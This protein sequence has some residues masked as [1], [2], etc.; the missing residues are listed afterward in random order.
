VFAWSA[1]GGS[2]STSGVFT[3]PTTGVTCTVTATSGAATGT[4]TVAL[5]ANAAPTVAQAVT[6]ISGATV[7]GK[8]ASLSVLGADDGGESNLIYRWSVTTAPAGAAATFNVNGTNAAKFTTVT[9]TKAGVYGLTATI[10]DSGGLCVS[11]V[12]TVVA[13]P[14]LASFSVT[15]GGQV[16][17]AASLLSVSG[18]SQAM[19][20]SGLDQFGNAIS[21]APTLTWSTTSFPVGAAAPKFISSGSTTTVTFGMAGSYALTASAPGTTLAPLTTS[22]SVN[23]TLTRIVLAP[24]A[25]DVLDGATQQFTPQALDQFAQPMANQ[26]AFTWTA[27]SGT[28]STFGLFT[29]PNTGTVCTVTVKSGAMT[30]TAAVTLLANP[31]TLQDPALAALVQS[32]DA[33]GSI[34]RNDMLAI[35]NNVATHSTVSATD[36]TD[37][38]EILYQAQA[39]TLTIPSYVQ[40][41]AGDVINGNLANATYQGKSLGNLAVGSSATQLNTLV[42]KWF[43]GTDVPALC[44]TSLTYQATAGTLFPQTPSHNDETQGSLGDC[45]FISALGTLADSNPAAVENMFINNGDGTYTVRFYTGTYGTMLNPD[46]TI[47]AGFNNNVGYADYVTVNSLL[48]ASATGILAYADCGSSVTNTANSLWIPLAEKA[49]AQWNQTGKAGRDDQNAYASIQA[50]WMATVDAQVVGQNA[51]DYIMTTT[52]EQ[53]AINAV[54]ANEA[55]T[56]GTLSWNGTEDGL[57]P[58]HAYAITGYNPSNDTFTLYNPWGNSQPNP[59]TWSQLQA[60]CSQLCVDN[61]AGSVVISSAVSTAGSVITSLSGG[62]SG[63]VVAALSRSAAV[64]VPADRAATAAADRWF[65]APAELFAG[66][67]SSGADPPHR[68]RDAATSDSTLSAPLVDA[69]LA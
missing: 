21:P 36:F 24:N 2:I 68:T 22:V 10:V 41:L 40:A 33:D 45:Y 55:V 17:T 13:S 37:L 50:G 48:P 46:G 44:N 43:L 31:G 30:G 39:G 67:D 42:S 34:S 26:Q 62:A 69:A 65:A 47:G 25:L 54:A 8:T 6:V 58:S 52:Q 12:G 29:A 3:A 51:T 53:V 38:K 23:Q 49:Y 19:V 35:F 63:T 60:T 15:A 59:L 16:L 7:T 1:S 4:A 57:Y 64:L 18:A 66:W 5:K 56:I 20:A 9:F 27:T 14:T 28:I 32:L 61:P 11:S